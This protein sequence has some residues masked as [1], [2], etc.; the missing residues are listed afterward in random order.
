VKANTSSWMMKCWKSGTAQTHNLQMF[1][2]TVLS[3]RCMNHNA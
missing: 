3:R 2:S 1:K